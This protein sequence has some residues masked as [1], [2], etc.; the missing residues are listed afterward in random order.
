M[1]MSVYIM[2]EFI[3]SI[4]RLI[5]LNKSAGLLIFGFVSRVFLR[6]LI[7]LSCVMIYSFIIISLISWNY[8]FLITIVGSML[9][10]FVSTYYVGLTSEERVIVDRVLRKMR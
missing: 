10:M 5:Y 4:I 6:I 8:R 9:M 1:V 2:F 3:C 7:P